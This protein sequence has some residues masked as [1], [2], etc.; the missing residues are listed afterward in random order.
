[1]EPGRFKISDLNLDQVSQMTED[2]ARATLEAIRWPNGPVC[3]HCG[4]TEAKRIDAASPKVRDGLLRCRACNKQFTVTIGT[5][6]EDSHIP[7]R[8][9]LLGIA[10]MCSSKKGISALQLKRNL[11]L[12]SYQSAWFMAHRIRYA[13]TM[14][15]LKSLLHGTVEVDETYIGSK[16]REGN[17]GRGSERKTPLV[18]LVERDGR[19]RTRVVA[20]VT[21][22][23]L[24]LAMYE[25]VRPD[26]MIMTDEFTVYGRWVGRDFA[27]HKTVN[28]ARKEYARGE[29]HVNT[30]ESFFA[31][32]K[33]GLHGAFHHVS[34]EHLGRYAEEFGFRWDRRKRTDARRAYDLVLNTMGKR[35]IYTVPRREETW[36]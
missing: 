34:K 27:G 11:G 30:A 4:G 24:K 21:A 32:F 18:A 20:N 3:P 14:E 23:N 33:R 12:G 6:F 22:K 10:L 26:A 16:T 19:I 28:H 29:A 9:W 25:T 31:L 5:L 35:L 1:M 13:M 36:Q 17:R 7:L 15:P 2:E 8:K